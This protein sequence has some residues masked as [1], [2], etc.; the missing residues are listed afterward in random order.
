MSFDCVDEDAVAHG[1]DPDLDIGGLV[2][3]A[4]QCHGA[5]S[6]Q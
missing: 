6:F 3:D 4:F 2:L 5:Q 1:E